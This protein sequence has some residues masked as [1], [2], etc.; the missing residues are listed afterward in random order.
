MG[1]KRREAQSR[2]LIRLTKAF[3][4]RET[5]QPCEACEGQG[6]RILEFA[7]GTYRRVECGWCENGLTDKNTVLMFARWKRIV[8]AHTKSGHCSSSS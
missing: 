2:R 4:N 8:A 6:S 3:N 5:L 1:T 7:N